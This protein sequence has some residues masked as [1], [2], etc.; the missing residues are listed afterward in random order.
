MDATN[1]K[2][3]EVPERASMAESMRFLGS[4]VTNSE[5][6]TKLDYKADSGGC[7]PLTKWEDYIKEHGKGGEWWD[8]ESRLPK[9]AERVKQADSA[10]AKASLVF[11]GLGDAGLWMQYIDGWSQ[12]KG[13]DSFGKVYIQDSKSGH[14]FADKL[15]KK[16]L[17]KKN[18][19]VNFYGKLHEIAFAGTG[20]ELK[21]D[22]N[23]RGSESWIYLPLPDKPMGVFHDVHMDG[24]LNYKKHQRTLEKNGKKPNGWKYNDG[25]L[26][27]WL[28]PNWS[29]ARVRGEVSAYLDEFF[30]TVGP[31]PAADKSARSKNLDAVVKIYH[32]LENLHPFIDGTGRTDML[33]LQLLLS[34]VGLHPVNFYNSMESALCSVEEQ[35]QKVLEGFFRWEETLQNLENGKQPATAW[36]L[37]NINKKN[38]E[39]KAAIEALEGTRETNEF[40]PDTIGGCMC[41]DAKECD[42]SHKCATSSSSCTW[43][44]DYCAKGRSSRKAK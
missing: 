11:N 25:Y 32:K 19:N 21:K 35:R 4:H 41:V 17:N 7:A 26:M 13:E 10:A 39:C 8:W 3:T 43:R 9:L 37:D 23:F 2:P 5:V 29:R 15:L 34:Y 36:N 20:K 24:K 42:N 6:H 12:L 16:G 31:N 18:A 40:V 38:E 1:L 27:R 22:N 44:W 14:S 30:R 28:Y 33:M